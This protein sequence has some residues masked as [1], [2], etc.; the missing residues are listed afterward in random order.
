[1]I[2][3]YIDMQEVALSDDLQ[4]DFYAYNP[5]FD[6]KSDYTY[7]ISIDISI[8]QN[9]VIY[10]HIDRVN[11]MLHPLNRIAELYDDT[12]LLLRGTEIILSVEESVVKVQLVSGNSELNYLA[13][14]KRTR[15][16]D[17]DLGEVEVSESS[18]LASLQSTS[19]K[20]DYVCAPCAK[21][22]NRFGFQF[23]AN[24][25][26]SAKMLYNNLSRPFYKDAEEKQTNMLAWSSTPNLR[27]M[28]YLCAMVEKVVESMGYKVVY[29]AIR[30]IPRFKQIYIVN[31][32][33]TKKY[34]EMV[35][36]WL[37][38]DFLDQIEK[39][40][41]VLFLVDSASK[42]CRII[43]INEFYTS[44]N[45]VAYIDRDSIVDHVDKVFDVEQTSEVSY[46]NV[47]YNVPDNE[48]FKFGVLDDNVR[49]ACKN[50]MVNTYTEVKGKAS[51]SFYNSMTL[52]HVK[53]NDREYVVS[54]R[55]VSA[56][57]NN[58]YYYVQP[59]DYIGKRVDDE[60][61]ESV[62]F[63]IVPAPMVAVSLYGF[64]LYDTSIASS[65]GG[66]C[67]C[68]GMIPYAMD[69]VSEEE[70]SEDK[71][72]N[73]FIVSGIKNEAV[74]SEMFVANYIGVKNCFWANIPSHGDGAVAKLKWPLSLSVQ[75]IV[76]F[77][78]IDSGFYYSDNREYSEFDLS[79]KSL[80]DDI[81]SKNEK[82]RTTEDVTVRF[83]TSKHLFDSKN[84]FVVAN[85]RF[86]CRYIKYKVTING[87]TE[88]A[89]G[90]FFPMK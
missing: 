26:R 71:G 73:E 35:P 39:W 38:N 37:V 83:Y 80:Y 68:F 10:K 23:W 12:T 3:L 67:N 2:H 53:E 5:F 41:N 25:E 89:E 24:K 52:Y 32:K 69:Q 55:K 56:D 6:R 51:E 60:S 29:N 54:R 81:Y 4:F 19:D 36:N 11:V 58:S 7:D 65:G 82:V 8:P 9:A 31:S 22:W 64:Y 66:Y 21:A 44:D 79:V 17:L 88:E 18:A 84:I 75:P 87:L 33:D 34:C 86:Y 48:F 78:A 16:Q 70:V 42:T 72:L 77:G 30:H 63:N 59:I 57:A 50:E 85:A 40:C 45:S 74:P 1:M 15:M 43:N 61:T 76:G 28:V 90:N 49:A 13:A 47:E 20:F 46:N 14:S 62:S 27:P